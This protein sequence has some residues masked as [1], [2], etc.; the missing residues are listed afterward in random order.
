[1]IGSLIL[2]LIPV[3]EAVELYALPSSVNIVPWP[4]REVVVERLDGISL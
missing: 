2:R 3:I 1:M 4:S